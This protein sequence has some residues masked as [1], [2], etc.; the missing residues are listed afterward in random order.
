MNRTH[1]IQ[2]VGAAACV[3]AVA[4]FSPLLTIYA[5]V[6]YA[7]RIGQLDAAYRHTDTQYVECS[8]ISRPKTYV[9][10]SSLDRLN[11]VATRGMWSIFALMFLICTSIYRM[12]ERND[13]FLIL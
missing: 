13:I 11:F 2:R 5:I 1:W 7:H 12:I 3:V 8:F 10:A 6:H 9:F 4:K